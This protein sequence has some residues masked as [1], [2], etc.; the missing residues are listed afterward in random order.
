MFTPTGFK[1]MTEF[2]ETSKI[3]GLTSA[4]DL[5][6]L[7]ENDNLPTIDPSPLASP[8]SSINQRD[9]LKI[10]PTS[11]TKE[12]NNNNIKLSFRVPS[13]NGT[14]T[15][16]KS[17]VVLW[18]IFSGKKLNSI[19]EDSSN[20]INITKEISILINSFISKSLENWTEPSKRGITDFIT[21]QMIQECLEYSCKD[22][23][24]FSLLC[25]CV[26]RTGS[27][28]DTLVT[29]QNYFDFVPKKVIKEKIK[30]QVKMKTSK[31]L[32]SK[33]IFF[34]KKSS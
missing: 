19:L 9:P 17:F 12:Y 25:S 18:I 15:L 20:Q 22:L 10:V 27:G 1:T 8:V 32:K 11:Q 7:L 33:R 28:L 14:L 23:S 29:S 5:L 13:G 2:Q 16:K 34:V 6:S 26:P 30:E 31:I 3:E 4:K 24:L 21:L